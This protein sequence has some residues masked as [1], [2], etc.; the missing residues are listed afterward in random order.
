MMGQ[1]NHFNRYVTE[2]VPYG[3]WRYTS[4]ARRLNHVLDKQLVSSSLNHSIGNTNILWLTELNTIDSQPPR[5]LLG[6]A[7]QLPTSQSS[8]SRTLPSGPASTSMSFLMSSCGMTSCWSALRF[9]KDSKFLCHISTVMRRCQTPA[10]R[11]STE[12]SG[13]LVAR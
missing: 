8:S 7:L 12:C 4:E 2:D 9:R 5:L 10:T 11:S 6:N 3:S 1:A 13:N